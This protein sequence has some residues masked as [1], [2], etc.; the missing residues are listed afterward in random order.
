VRTGEAMNGLVPVEMADAPKGFAK[1]GF[2]VID[3][4]VIADVLPMTASGTL[5]VRAVGFLAIGRMFEDLNDPCC[6]VVLLL[7]DDL[8]LDHVARRASRHEDYPLIRAR[9]PGP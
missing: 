6:R 1:D 4:P 8:D 3:L 7:S 5:I 2:L 9:K